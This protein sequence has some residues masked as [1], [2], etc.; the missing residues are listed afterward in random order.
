MPQCHNPPDRITGREERVQDGLLG[1]LQ[2]AVARTSSP[3]RCSRDASYTETWYAMSVEEPSPQPRYSS[4]P[5]APAER[6]QFKLLG[7]FTS[8]LPP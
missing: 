2:S 5:L 8:H 7:H 1:R 6:C 3:S 4:E